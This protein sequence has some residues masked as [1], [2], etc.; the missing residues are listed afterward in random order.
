MAD[1]RKRGPYQLQVRI[2]RKGY[3]TQVKTF[4]TKA[5]AEA[6]A[7][8]TESKMVR[9]VFV[10]RKETENATLDKTLDGY[11][12]EVTENKKMDLSGNPPCR[13]P[14]NT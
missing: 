5:E 11:L 1:L 2:R 10:S 13:E 12:K 9:G 6:W 7:E 8:T 3:S 14:Q 4:N